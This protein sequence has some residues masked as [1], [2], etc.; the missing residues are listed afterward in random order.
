MLRAISLL[1]FWWGWTSLTAQVVYQS[2]MTRE[3]NSGKKPVPNV[4]IKF[5][6]A[7]NTTSDD[8]GKFRLAFQGKNPGDVAFLSEIFKDGYEVVNQK[9]LEITKISSGKQL[10]EDIIL[11]PVGTIAAARKQYYQISD[12]ALHAKFAAEREA[13]K[14]QLQTAKLQQEAFLQQ[15]GSLEEAYRLQQARLAD[16]SDRFARVNFD[17]VEPLFQEALSF[18]QQGEIKQAI[19]ILESAKLEERTQ[20]LLREKR[21]IADREAELAADKMA[22]QAEKEQQLAAIKLLADLYSVNFEIEK[23][24]AQYDAL[25]LLD[26]TDLTIIQ[27]AALFYFEQ[28]RYAK[29]QRL[30]KLITQHPEA[31]RTEK[32]SAYGNL[33]LLSKKTGQLADA[34]AQY[35][36]SLRMLDSLPATDLKPFHTYLQSITYQDLS[37]IH[38]ERGNPEAANQYR[39]KALSIAQKGYQQRAQYAHYQNV[40]AKAYE[41]QAAYFDEIGAIDSA[42][43]YYRLAHQVSEEIH[44]NHPKDP[45]FLEALAISFS[46]LGRLSTL[47]GELDSAL[48]FFRK[49]FH[50]SRNLRQTYPHQIDYAANLALSQQ[51]LG[52]TYRDLGLIDSARE[53]LSAS[54]V[55]HEELYQTFPANLKFSKGLGNA[56]ERLGSLYEVTGQLDTALS[57]YQQDLTL[58]QLL[59]D[60]HPDQVET[61]LNLAISYQKVGFTFKNLGKL[62]SAQQYFQQSL[63]L[64]EP[65]YQQFPDQVAYQD[66]LAITLQFIGDVFYEQAQL[67]SALHYYLRF[68]RLKEE[69]RDRAPEIVDYQNGLAIAYGKIG[70]LYAD[71]G[72]MTDA[73]GWY[74]KRA[75]ISQQLY[76]SYPSEPDLKLTHANSHQLLGIIYTRLQEADS[77]QFHLTAYQSLAFELSRDFPDQV[78]YQQALRGAYVKLG[79]FYKTDQQGDSALKYYQLNFAVCQQLSAEF[80][81]NVGIAYPYAQSIGKLAE[82]YALTGQFDQARKAYQNQIQVFLAFRETYPQNTRFTIAQILSHGNFGAFYGTYQSDVEAAKAQYQEALELANL[83]LEKRPNFQP[84]TAYID[85]LE[86]SLQQLEHPAISEL[87]AEIQATEALSGKYQLQAVLCDSL[88]QMAQVHP[89]FQ[90]RLGEALNQKAWWGLSLGHYQQSELDSREAMSL[91]LPGSDAH[92]NLILALLYQEKIRE[93]KQMYRRYLDRS[94]EKPDAPLFSEDFLTELSAMQADG[95]LPKAVRREAEKIRRQLEK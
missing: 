86:L 22:L 85:H 4:F 68:A 12:R 39:K 81:D 37:D 11:A 74:Q 42:H 14:R 23:A 6:D 24:E 54:V 95:K 89:A 31:D 51:D 44:Q 91:K 63:H 15:I 52:R 56:Y 25:V 62:D 33:G 34:L 19:Q 48:H 16:L 80:P 27:T 49:D 77:A 29:A 50:I 8:Q 60:Q 28:H 90:L 82:A 78:A 61:R 67:D 3:L 36:L 9:A 40:L 47:R 18:F 20:Q 13:L 66:G 70:R 59:N 17:D 72:A 1:L 73:L 84:L 57:Y 21:R 26:S 7:V 45:F 92:L 69:L 55:L 83:L 87:E 64:K 65:L 30:Y 58:Y 43:Y 71:V 38:W 10:G 5:E 93:A 76:Q 79:D 2:G 53:V 41:H 32:A 88:R 35:L 46:H 94:A 75:Q